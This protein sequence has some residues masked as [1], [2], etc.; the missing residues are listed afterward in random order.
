M[1]KEWANKDRYH[2]SHGVPE[3]R[4]PLPKGKGFVRKVLAWGEKSAMEGRGPAGG[5]K[6]VRP[7]LKPVRPVWRQQ[8]TSLVFVLVMS[9]G[10]LQEVVV[11][12][13]GLESLQVV[14]LL[15]DL[16]LVINTRLGEVAALSLRGA[17]YHAFPIMVVVL[18]L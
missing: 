1:A 3:P 4:M 5:V 13:V 7:V 9:L 11:L 18:L 8:G 17:T 15:D 12:V 14:S 16:H 10:L 2:P 6:P